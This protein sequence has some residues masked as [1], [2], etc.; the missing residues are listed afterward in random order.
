MYMHVYIYIH[1]Y[2]YTYIY[3]YIYVCISRECPSGAYPMQKVEKFIDKLGWAEF[4]TMLDLAP[5]DLL[6]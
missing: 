1:I 6:Q 2:T 5:L 4:I 3:T